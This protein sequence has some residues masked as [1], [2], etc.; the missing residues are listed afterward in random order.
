MSDREDDVIIIS[1]ECGAELEAS[2]SEVGQVVACGAC[3]R[4]VTVTLPEAAEAPEAQA[5]AERAW[6]YAKDNQQTGPVS[7]GGMHELFKAG[8]IGPQTLVWTESLQAWAYASSFEVFQAYVSAAPPA[9]RKSGMLVV[10]IAVAVPVI[11]VVVAIIGILA[12]IVLPAFTKARESARRAAC[13]NNLKQMGLVMVM[14]ANENKGRYPTIDN[15]KGNFIFEG[16]QVYPEYLTDV[17]ILGCPSDPN[18]SVGAARPDSITSKSYVYLG[19]AV[20]SE[21][22]GLAVLDAYSR[23][24]QRELDTDLS[25]AEGEGSGGGSL[26]LRLSEDIERRI[27]DATPYDSILPRSE[28]PVPVYNAADYSAIPIMWEW[29]SSHVPAVANVLYLDGHVEFIRYPGRFPMTEAFVEELRSF[30]PG[31]SPD[32]EPIVDR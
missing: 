16:D 8:T 6:Y 5:A 27:I 14:Y 20:T 32:V 22:Q 28:R 30:E 7:E 29:P 1:C 11:L 21:A 24:S 23:A 31:L 19:W 2:A 10:L 3:G 13:T 15:V 12:A 25:V 4:D 18:Y 9:K 26:I 17:A